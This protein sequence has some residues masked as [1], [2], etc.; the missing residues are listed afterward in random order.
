MLVYSFHRK[1]NRLFFFICIVLISFSFSHKIFLENP[2]AIAYNPYQNYLI[3]ILF[4]TKSDGKE[5]LDKSGDMF[6]N[7]RIEQ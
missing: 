7:N 1:T 6:I 2:I 5:R 3:H 4:D